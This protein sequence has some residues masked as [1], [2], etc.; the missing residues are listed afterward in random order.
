MVYTKVK[1]NDNYLSILNKNPPYYPEMSNHH[2][3]P[4]SIFPH[5]EDDETNKIRIPDN[6]HRSLHRN[7]SN[8]KIIQDP[9]G[10]L[11]KCIYQ[12]TPSKFKERSVLEYMGVK[13]YWTER[14]CSKLAWRTFCF[15]NK[16]GRIKIK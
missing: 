4:I 12:R 9:I 13:P 5:L 11:I 8:Y 3:L 14:V 15:F 6:I 1:Y 2:I 7:F 10:Y 16:N